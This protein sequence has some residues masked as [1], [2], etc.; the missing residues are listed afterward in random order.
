MYYTTKS[1]WLWNDKRPGSNFLK[2]IDQH[3]EAVALAPANM[4]TGWTV[5]KTASGSYCSVTASVTVAAANFT[6]TFKPD[7]GLTTAVGEGWVFGPYTGVFAQ[8]TMT[9]Q[10][11]MIG[12]NISSQQG[13]IFWR[14][15][16]AN[17]VV[18]TSPT[19]VTPVVQ[20]TPIGVVLA[21]GSLRLSSSYTMT[22]PLS[23]A[24][25]YLFLEAAWGITT[26][27]GANAANALFQRGSGSFF[28]FN[29]V[30]EDN[31][32]FIVGDDMP[33]YA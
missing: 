13:R 8:S 19:L 9:F 16:R 23:L 31:T 3:Q 25:E 28:K 1:I 32:I 14:L 20:Q 6:T 33:G 27:A 22:Q 12:T 17:D 10:A 15:W 18:G 29:G 21:N 5:A 26:A 2:G 4:T 11:N 7:D 24:N 30:Y